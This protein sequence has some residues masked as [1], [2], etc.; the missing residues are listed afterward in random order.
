MVS[1]LLVLSA[2]LAAGCGSSSD[3]SSPP[4]QDWRPDAAR[5]SQVD[6]DASPDAVADAAVDLDASG[7]APH[8]PPAAPWTLYACYYGPPTGI[9]A[10]MACGAGLAYVTCVING[11]YIG[12]CDG[13]AQCHDLTGIPGGW[14][15]PAGF[16]AS[17]STCAS[18]VSKY[19]GSSVYVCSDA[20]PTGE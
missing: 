2:L 12:F 14:V 19:S 13:S 1:R 6:A 5:E 4:L 11:Q 17:N 10:Q 3:G 18:M 15:C 20:G 7:D 9:P 16:A 8:A